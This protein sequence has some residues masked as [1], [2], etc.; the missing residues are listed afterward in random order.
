VAC[1]KST[2]G[3]RLV[4]A[5][6]GL[7][8]EDAFVHLVVLLPALLEEFGWRGFGV[9]TAMEADGSPLWAALVV[10]VVFT[11][12]HLPLY[13][14]GQIYDDVP[15]WP[16]PLVLLSN[17][18]LLTWIFVGSGES[19][20]LAGLTHAASNGTV[21]LTSGADSDWVFQARA[22]VFSTIAIIVVV[23][24]PLFATRPRQRRQSGRAEG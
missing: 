13:L 24:S 7:D 5:F 16:L 11:L 21:P 12:A 9:A 10:G 14:P 19:S 23:L 20:F 8:A 6:A 1:N 18:I 2:V 15:L 22:I 4:S 3:Y 17:S